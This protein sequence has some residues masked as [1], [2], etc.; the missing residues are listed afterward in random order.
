MVS[1]ERKYWDPEI[2]TM[3]R[4]QI[5][6]LQGERLWKQVRYVYEKSD[7][8]RELYQNAGI[9]PKD[10]KGIDD[11]GRLPIIEKEDLRAFRNKTGDIF[12][13]CLCTPLENLVKTHRS[14]GTSGL[15]NI[16]GLTKGDFD[17]AADTFA[18]GMYGIGMRKE[19][20][21][22]CPLET[23]LS[24]HGGGPA[25]TE[26]IRKIGCSV[27]ATCQ[28][29]FSVA[30]DLFEM[31]R[32]AD[33][34]VSFVYHPEEEVKYIRENNIV[35]K[36]IF[37][38]LR[39]VYTLASLSASSRAIM[40]RTWGVPVRNCAGSG[41]QYFCAPECEFSVPYFHFM[42]DRCLVEVLDP[43]T[44]KP[45]APGEPGELVVS[46]LWAEATPYL[47]YRMEDVVIYDPEPCPCGNT[48]I[49]LRYLGRFA[50]SINVKGKLIFTDDVEDVLWRCSETELSPYQ[51][52]RTDKQPQDTLIVRVAADKERIED[53]DALRL[54]LAGDLAREFGVPA[55]IEFIEPGEIGAGELK[56]QR[57]LERKG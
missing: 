55:D 21:V 33:I 1:H 41:D 10:I 28:N 22:N 5:K 31:L 40:E 12:S 4:D 8:F 44:W 17:V 42:E 20:T 51:L 26:G 19:D 6:E 46:N 45:V 47:R 48:H 7:F 18:R 57:V 50:W 15:P 54:K 37:P 13:G 43:D 39:F 14:T 11:L 24:W 38:N 53:I 30:P 34:T 3:P 9:E 32:G 23:M 2:E 52:V 56:F 29:V 36:E 49:K 35:P 27:L 16:Y 25:I